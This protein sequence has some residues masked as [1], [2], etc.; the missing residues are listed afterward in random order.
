MT[1]KRSKIEIYLEILKTLKSGIDKPTNVMYK[2]NL[3]WKPFKN[4][5]KTLIDN[6]LIEIVDRGSRR[7]FKLT[8]K[9]QEFLKQFETAEAILVD[10]RKTEKT[11]N[12]PYS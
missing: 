6:R 4:D 9:G 1:R 11:S 2:C 10:L 5:L 7:T 3:A 8:E 12:I